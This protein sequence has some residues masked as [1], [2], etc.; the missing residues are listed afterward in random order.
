MICQPL[1]T[2]AIVIA[3]QSPPSST[4]NS[5][6]DGLPF[7]QGKAD[8]QEMYPKV[9]I[10]STSTQRKEAEPG[11]ILISVRA[12][13]GTV[14]I[15]N[16]KSIIGRGLSAIR[17]TSSLDGKFL[18][19]YLKVN[20][21][22]IDALGTGSTFKAITQDTLKRVS[23]PLPTLDDQKRIA[24]LLGKVEMA[25]T[26][27]K[28]NLQQ[29]DDLLTSIFLEMFDDPVRNEKG[30]ETIPFSKIGKFKG[31]G[32]P[33]KS[34]DDFWS[35]NFPWV[36]PKD[37]KISRVDDSIDH[38]SE[39][40]FDETL[41]KR[42]LPNHLLIV[43]RGMIL[44]HSFPVAINTVT[45]AIN[46]DMKAIKPIEEINV[47]YLANCLSALKR[48]ILKL[49]TVAGHGTRR[50]DSNAMEMLLIPK[51]PIDLQ[52]QFSTI[53]EKIEGIKSRYQQSLT[54]LETL[55]GVLSQK[56]FKGELDLSRVPLTSEVTE[57]TAEEKNEINEPPQT[58]DT[59]KLPAPSNLTTLNSTKGRNALLDQWL[60]V[61]LGHLKNTP[62]STQSF[63]EAAQQNLWTLAEED[64][65]E[66]ELGT[67]EY[68]YVQSWIFESLNENE[69]HL[70]QTYDDDN[71]KVQLIAVVT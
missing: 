11:D 22:Q 34:R 32:T 53:S 28:Q 5:V 42:I 29:L 44:A 18:Y 25:I 48:Q 19:Y 16:Q 30:W 67:A 60:T 50:F 9:R 57:A 36:S 37:M 15:C 17:P 20:E 40:V 23:V 12:P 26:Q 46:Q 52:N 6:G 24:H 47:V 68:D 21:K 58:T 66:W 59:F 65:L 54:D 63:I 7:F 51:P 4:Y 27:R 3:G 56:A 61:W 1:G 31:G 45:V 70:T 2:I 10:W 49:V 13:V 69:G 8:F 43:V 39:V 71:K 14:N 35:G 33:S 55:Y 62:F 41:L 64:A 38:I